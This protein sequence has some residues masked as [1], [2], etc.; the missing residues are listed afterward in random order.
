MSPLKIPP[1]SGH[2]S[3]KPDAATRKGLRDFTGPDAENRVLYINAGFFRYGT[4]DKAHAASIALSMV[5]L[6]VALLVMVVGLFSSNVVW[7]EKMQAWI[8]SAF[9]FVAGV[10][11][12]RGGRASKRGK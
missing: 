4:D 7:L 8:G 6:L 1:P 11:I 9:L 10:A 5:L 3:E 2:L 12:G